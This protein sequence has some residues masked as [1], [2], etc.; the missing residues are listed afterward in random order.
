VKVVVAMSGGVDSS[1]AAALLKSEG[2]DVIGATMQIWP[3][4]QQSQPGGCCSLSAVEDARRVANLIG[5]PHYVL[6]LQDEFERLVIREFIA[7]YG[8]GH[9]PNPCVRCNQFVK[10]DVLLRKAI[11]LGADKIA[12]G[13][14]A[15]VDYD[16]TAGRWLLK[17]SADRTKDQSYALYTMTQEQLSRTL[18]PL[19]DR[20]KPQTRALAAKLGMSV[21]NKPDSQEICFIPDNKYAGFLA[22]AAPELVSP[23]P[24]VDTSGNELGT[25]NGIAFYTIGQRKRLGIAVGRPMYVVG[26]DRAKNAVVVGSNEELFKDTVIAKNM[27]FIGSES[28]ADCV[29]VSAKIRYNMQD[30]PAYACSLDDNAVRLRFDKPQRAV[31]PGQ[32]MVMYRDEIVVGGGVIADEQEAAAI[33]AGASN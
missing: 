26:I 18:F 12:T 23:G 15:R 11:S 10:F 17:R 21:A 16:E 28:L 7:E 6:N 14:Y 20:G 22:K 24:I 4:S 2:H 29:V 25:H 9:T 31:T 1:V 8:L 19:G 3:D 30:S 27:N 32:A 13:H 33:L 5:I